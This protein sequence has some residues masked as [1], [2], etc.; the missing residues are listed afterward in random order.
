MD[1]PWSTSAQRLN[2]QYFLGTNSASFSPLQ[3][4]DNV[5]IANGILRTL[6]DGPL[7]LTSNAIPYSLTGV[8]K[9]TG[10]DVFYIVLDKQY[11]S[12]IRITTKD[13]SADLVVG[14]PF[15]DY[16]LTGTSGNALFAH[17]SSDPNFVED[18][19]T[20]L[21]ITIKAKTNLSGEYFGHIFVNGALP[22]FGVEKVVK[23]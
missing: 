7:D 21:K 8:S 18:G 9:T 23:L 14:V 3:H 22:S 16:S 20:K 15:S 2:D 13:G 11:Q 4:R 12:T 17:S 10:Q 6:P 19:R 5:F 1:D